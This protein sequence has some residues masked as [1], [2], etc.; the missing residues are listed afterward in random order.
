[1]RPGREL[2]AMIAKQV[3]GYPVTQQKNGAL[4]EGAPK[5]VRPLALYSKDMTAAWEVVEKMAMTLIPIEG[6]SWFALVGNGN[7]FKSPADFLKYVQCADF[8]KAG[9]AV[10][11]SAPLTIC[12]AALRSVENRESLESGVPRSTGGPGSNDAL[13]SS[14]PSEGAG[15]GPH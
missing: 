7:R 15:S 8:V 14:D 10:G 2:D 1:M 3:L 5:G 4:H 11:E 6:D 12:L 13:G 9:A